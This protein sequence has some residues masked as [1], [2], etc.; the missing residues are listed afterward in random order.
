MSVTIISAPAEGQGVGQSPT[1]A[2]PPKKNKTKWNKK[3]NVFG[4]KVDAIWAK[5]NHTNFIC[6]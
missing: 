5:I 2:P 1:P 4:E 3:K 6:A